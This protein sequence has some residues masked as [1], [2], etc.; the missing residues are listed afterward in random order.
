MK[1]VVSEDGF[2][3]IFVNTDLSVQQRGKAGLMFSSNDSTDV[4]AERDLGIGNHRGKK[5]GMGVSALFTVD[6]DDRECDYRISKLD[7]AL[8]NSMTD[9][10]P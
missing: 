3:V 5:E 8:I 4:Q 9:Q 6:P 10:A 1:L 7:S 2:Q